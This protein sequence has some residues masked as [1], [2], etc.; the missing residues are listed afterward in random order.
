MPRSACAVAYILSAALVL[1]LYCVSATQSR[2][3]KDPPLA[4]EDDVARFAYST[5][6]EHALLEERD[7]ATAVRHVVQE[8]S[9]GFGNQH[10]MSVMA[11]T[12]G[13]ATGRVVSLAPGH[14]GARSVYPTVFHDPFPGWRS[15]LRHRARDVRLH[16]DDAGSVPLACLVRERHNALALSACGLDEPP[17][18]RLIGSTSWV[19]RL[20]RVIAVEDAL[21]TRFAPVCEALWAPAV[22]HDADWGSRLLG[23]DTGRPP[24][25][26]ALDSLS[27]SH[28]SALLNLTS[29]GCVAR[30]LLRLPTLLAAALVA[31]PSMTL[32]RQL[33]DAKASLRWGDDGAAVR[34]GLHLRHYADLRQRASA[35]AMEDAH[36]CVRRIVSDW[37]AMHG[38]GK[39]GPSHRDRAVRIFLATD[40]PE[41]RHDTAVALSSVGAVVWLPNSS[42][43]HHSEA[44][45][46]VPRE[47]RRVLVDWLLL[48]E[49]DLLIGTHMSSFSATAA[50]ARPGGTPFAMLRLV[51]GYRG[52]AAAPMHSPVR[53]RPDGTVDGRG[54]DDLTASDSAAPR[55]GRD[56]HAEPEAG[57]REDG[58]ALRVKPQGPRSDGHA[59]SAT[60]TSSSATA[61]VNGD[62]LHEPALNWA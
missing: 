21:A 8:L 42:A 2:A 25:A 44:G 33:A 16:V 29:A 56:P 14:S 15:R 60:A 10:R 34:V 52:Q 57:A 35:R 20:R 9:N 55:G 59:S 40:R 62:C 32:A 7:N 41:T 22:Q 19:T 61:M 28:R 39:P 47:T 36:A 31:H 50:A 48:S 43:F 13:L 27:S 51:V 24:P 26:A 4:N 17:S 45:D 1:Q 18:L 12:L 54:A 37:I 49:A 5:L 46:T 23:R 53:P 11:L 6:M 38:G 3:L 58:S 30:T